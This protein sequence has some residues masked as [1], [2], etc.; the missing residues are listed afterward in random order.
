MKKIWHGTPPTQC[1][2]CQNKIAHQFIDGKTQM[3]PWANMCPNCFTVHGIQ[4]G[5]G[6]GQKYERDET[7]IFYKTEG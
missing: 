7:G 5:E 3:G 4:L 1:D 6:F 2:L